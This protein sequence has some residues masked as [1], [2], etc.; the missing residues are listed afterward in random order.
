MMAALPTPVSTGSAFARGYGETPPQRLRGGRVRFQGSLSIPIG[1]TPGG[2]GGL[3]L[4][5]TVD[6]VHMWK[7]LLSS[8][9]VV[10][11]IAVHAQAPTTPAK[12]QEG[13]SQPK[14]APPA[15][16]PAPAPK[17]TAP[18]TTPPATTPPATTP[19]AT[20]PPATTTP[21]A[22]RRAPATNSRAGMTITVTDPKGLTLPGIQVGVTGTTT[23]SGETDE[24]GN[25][26]F[27]GLMAGTYRLRFDGENWISFEREVTLSAGKVQDVDVALNPAPEPPPPPAPAPAPEP[28]APAT[29]VGPKGQPQTVAILDWLDKEFVGRDP[30]RE[31]ILAC[32]GNE[33]TTILQLNEPMPQR[34]YEEA[35]VVYYVLGGEGS[36]SLD[37]KNARITT[38]GFVSVPRGTPHSFEKRGNRPLMLLAV[39]GGEPCEKAK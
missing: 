14:P 13:T 12:P 23:R 33:R 31:S 6:N 15:T 38:N 5:R 1:D 24:S 36:V 18:A 25:I 20:T 19:P 29:K 37:G 16:T 34:L 11:V 2:L 26:N 21:A 28:V 4:P 32:S 27:T 8:F 3:Y 30:R 39:L 17:P 35:D 22:P 10:G 7:V 9:I